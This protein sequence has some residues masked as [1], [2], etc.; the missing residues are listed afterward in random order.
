M[1]IKNKLNK[2]TV[3]LSQL[4][5]RDPKSNSFRLRDTQKNGVA[6]KLTYGFRAF[7][8]TLRTVNLLTLNTL[9]SAKND[10]L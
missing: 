7:F 5:L 9:M 6:W 4:N 1:I 3:Y 2:H 10:Y 8:V